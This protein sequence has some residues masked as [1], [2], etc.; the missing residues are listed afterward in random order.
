VLLHQVFLTQ[1]ELNEVWSGG[2]GSYTLIIMIAAFLQLHASRR[3]RT[4]KRGG[5][6]SGGGGSGHKRS[7]RDHEGDAAPLD[8]N[9]GL[10]LVDMMR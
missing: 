1:R 6:G 10:L 8:S 2:V 5:G 7:R 3:P 4:S 9:L